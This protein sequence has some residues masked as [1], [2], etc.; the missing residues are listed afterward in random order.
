M[1]VFIQI[2]P[3]PNSPIINPSMSSIIPNAKQ[4]VVANNSNSDLT[5]TDKGKLAAD[6]ASL[7][8][9]NSKSTTP[10]FLLTFEIFNRN[11]H[12]CM[13]DSGASSNVMPLSVCKRL[14]GKYVPSNSQIAQ[15]DRTNV[16][17][18]AEM[19]YVLVR[20]ACNPS[21][22]QIIDIVIADIPDAYGLF[23]SRDWSQQ[24]NGFFATNWSTL[25]FLK[26]ENEIKLR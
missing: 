21:V 4:S 9:K 15:L 19:K 20:I 26:M 3:M 10:P 8:G 16:G 14:N 12:N 23:L 6:K 1:Y 2:Y 5:S 25:W 18:V 17:V 11:V 22:F 7:I 13:D 24:L